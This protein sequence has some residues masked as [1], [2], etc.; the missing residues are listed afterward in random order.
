MCERPAAGYRPRWS[1]SYWNMIKINTNLDSPLSLQNPYKSLKL[2]DILDTDTLRL[3]NNK[4]KVS[5]LCWRDWEGVN[6][7]LSCV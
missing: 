2:K 1:C 5:L 7:T 3:E 6:P 4:Y